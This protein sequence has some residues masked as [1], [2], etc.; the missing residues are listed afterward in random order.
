VN[1]KVSI[2]LFSFI[3][4]FSLQADRKR[5]TLIFNNIQFDSHQCNMQKHKH[6]KFSFLASE[7]NLEK[8]IKEIQFKKSIYIHEI[9]YFTEDYIGFPYGYQKNCVHIQYCRLDE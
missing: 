8:T 5:D 7:V 6:C 9:E 2:I 3:I 1:T 4:L